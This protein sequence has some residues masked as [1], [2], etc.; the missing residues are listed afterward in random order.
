MVIS[1]GRLFLKIKQFK[2]I[3]FKWLLV[4]LTHDMKILGSHCCKAVILFLYGG[5][6]YKHLRLAWVII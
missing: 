3:F 6:Y 2:D 4:A 5:I 1:G